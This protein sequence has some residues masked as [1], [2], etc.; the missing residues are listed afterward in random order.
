VVFLLSDDAAFVTGQCLG[1]DGG[2]AL[3]GLPEPEHGRLLRGLLPDFF[4]D[5]EP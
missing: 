1:V 3:R 2:L 5:G 4:G